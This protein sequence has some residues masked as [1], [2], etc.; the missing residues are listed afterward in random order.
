M[1]RCNCSMHENHFDAYFYF[2][3][4][5][6]AMEWCVYIPMPEGLQFDG[7]SV[8]WGRGCNRCG[9]FPKVQSRYG[10]A[11]SCKIISVCFSK[12]PAPVMLDSTAVISGDHDGPIP[13]QYASVFEGA[14]AH[15]HF[16][17]HVKKC[18]SHVTNDHRS[19][20]S[21]L[22]LCV[23]VCVICQKSWK[24]HLSG[25]CLEKQSGPHFWGTGR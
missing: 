8:T 7:R 2:F 14:R 19:C 23:C 15:F 3:S 25:L 22:K 16:L 11:A 10:R 20:Q 12:I 17:C 18:W 9:A 21:T 5:R 13:D 1:Q 6:V 24:D 4:P